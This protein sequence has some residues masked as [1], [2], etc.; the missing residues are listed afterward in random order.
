MFSPIIKPFIHRKF[1]IMKKVVSLLIARFSTAPPAVVRNLQIILIGLTVF[2]FLG[3]VLKWNIP[4]VQELFDWEVIVGL[5]T[6]ALGAQGINP[7]IKQQTSDDPPQD[8][9]AGG[10]SNP[11]GP[12]TNP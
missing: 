9:N 5:L 7:P 12:R 8:P 6:A 1:E 11:G 4:A 2:S 10:S 3:L